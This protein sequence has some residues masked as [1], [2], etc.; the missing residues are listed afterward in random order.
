VSKRHPLLI[1]IWGLVKHP[2]TLKT[3]LD[4]KISDEPFTHDKLYDAKYFR[5]VERTTA[6]SAKAIS[7]SIVQSL[8][9]SSLIDVGCGT[10]V[11]IECLQEQGVQV[12]GLELAEAALNLCRERRLDVIKFDVCT[13]RLPPEF[14][15]ADVAVSMSVGHQLS[16]AFADRYV[17][18]L[19]QIAPTVVFSSA[20]P[21]R[22]DRKP[23]NEQPHQYCID[24]FAEREYRFDESLSKQWRHD[25]K[26]QKAAPWFQQDVMIFYKNNA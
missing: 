4:E 3:I 10:G 9:P 13:D 11:L 18:V 5:F 25:W 21:G 20:T 7:S 14:A 12:K 1:T 17:D 24:K 6:R 2:D 23:L 15:H 26:A 22:G 19:C 8:H 16:E